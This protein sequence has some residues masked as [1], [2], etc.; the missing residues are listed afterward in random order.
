[1]IPII[2]PFST[3]TNS[4][5]PFI[6]I[7]MNGQMM[8]SYSLRM[9]MG[10]YLNTGNPVL[11]WMIG[12]FITTLLMGLT[13]FLSKDNL[14][15]LLNKIKKLFFGKEKSK[16]KENEVMISAKSVTIKYSD[17]TETRYDKLDDLKQH[18]ADLIKALYWYLNKQR[19]SAKTVSLGLKM[20]QNHDFYDEQVR[21]HHFLIRPTEE[22]SLE[23]GI[24]IKCQLEKLKAQKSADNGNS[25]SKR[26]NRG[27]DDQGN[28]D[29][30]GNSESLEET[31][32]LSSTQP[33]K[34]IIEFVEQIW[35]EYIDS[36]IPLIDRSQENK[37]WYFI[38]SGKDV[39]DR[40]P[41]S[42]KV[43]FEDVF[44]PEKGK[45]LRRVNQFLNNET[46]FSSFKILAYGKPGGGKTSLIKALHN[47]TGFHVIVVRLDQISTLTD[48]MKLFFSEK[49]QKKSGGYCQIPINQRI[50]LLEDI[51]A[52]SKIVL[53]RDDESDDEDDN[54]KTAAV[55][56]TTAVI[57]NQTIPNQTNPNQS[58]STAHNHT[59]S[60]G[61]IK[62]SD[63][64]DNWWM[65]KYKDSKKSDGLTLA[66][67][68]NLLDG[69][70]E[71]D[72]CFIVMTTNHLE[73]LDPALVRDGR[74]SFKIELK[75]ITPPHMKAMISN[76]H[77]EE[78]PNPKEPNPEL[79]PLLTQLPKMMPCEFEKLVQHE[80]NLQKII[81]NLKAKIQPPTNLLHPVEA[82]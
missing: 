76:F 55:I 1:M 21:D 73:K 10:R 45:F 32:T 47:H 64:W 50:Y 71:L 24:K 74:I 12:G 26:R 65:S 20:N 3:R 22:L 11:D 5:E 14:S 27:D 7:K 51:D 2:Q 33:T 72:G 9:T 39:Y 80:D 40:Y 8:D 34:S 48:L 43:S 41:L 16:P 53:K 46:K 4:I 63:P 6:L 67:I 68:L 49:I 18:N 38:R 62:V 31:I 19:E 36:E 35:K 42:S 23:N 66:N 61:S 30:N 79:D 81:D 52:D 60:I 28:Q 78:L 75:E 44:F 82:L 59:T 57:Q 70:L 29:Q 13:G 15:N 25:D 37:K 56:P 17:F 69:V 58:I 54:P 77:P